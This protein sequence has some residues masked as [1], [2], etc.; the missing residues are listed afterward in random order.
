[1]NH[2]FDALAHSHSTY[3]VSPTGSKSAKS[4]Q[5]NSHCTTSETKILDSNQDAE[6]LRLLSIF[7]Y[8]VGGIVGLFS[9][10]PL[11]YIALGIAILNGAFDNANGGESP[12]PAF[13]GW[14]C[15]LFPLVFIVMGLTLAIH[16][17]V[18][19]RRL[20]QRTG[21]LYCL[22]IAGLECFFMP[23]GTVLGVLTI[24]LL[25]RPSVKAMFVGTTNATLGKG[26]V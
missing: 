5:V 12:P 22:V 10:F 9:L 24:L 7:H 26:A 16:I 2:T 14:L 19:G 17:A 13:M 8:I 21:H 25:L 11:I 4:N 15:I 20:N 18:A 6:Y 3:R 1:M 23:F